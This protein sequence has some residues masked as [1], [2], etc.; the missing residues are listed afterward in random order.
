MVE[1]YKEKIN[2][3][4]MDTSKEKQ[5]EK[6][7]TFLLT[8]FLSF[9]HPWISFLFIY[10]FIF[11]FYNLLN[12]FK[13][14]TCVKRKSVF[15]VSQK[16]PDG[17]WYTPLFSKSKR[18]HQLPFGSI[19]GKSLPLSL[20]R[21]FFLYFQGLSSDELSTYKKKLEFLKY[22]KSKFEFKNCLKFCRLIS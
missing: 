8:L 18:K 5:N 2:L 15:L 10:L 6:M 9:F 13:V 3:C 14:T 12:F 22:L 11:C 7:I 21:F 19:N 1:K 4:L 20:P 16:A 17:F